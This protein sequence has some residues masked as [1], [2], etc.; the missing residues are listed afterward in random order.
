MG[1]QRKEVLEEQLGCLFFVIERILSLILRLKMTLE[2]LTTSDLFSLPLMNCI[3][4]LSQNLMS[5]KVILLFLSPKEAEVVSYVISIRLTVICE[6]PD[7][8]T[9]QEGSPEEGRESKCP[10]VLP[11][12]KRQ[13]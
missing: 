7:K 8:R 5:Y 10:V 6:S 13:E 1:S 11:G 3:Q 2:K 12:R 4:I 9:S